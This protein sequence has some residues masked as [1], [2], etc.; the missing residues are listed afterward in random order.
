MGTAGAAHAAAAVCLAVWLVVVPS[1]GLP[2][3]AVG[4]AIFTLLAPLLVAVSPVLMR[5]RRFPRPRLYASDGAFALLCVASFSGALDI[6]GRAAIALVA[7]VSYVAISALRARGELGSLEGV[8]STA[9][10][11]SFPET[12][13]AGT[14]VPM[15]P[16]TEL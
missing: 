7:I 4:Y 9:A 3:V 12:S 6:S 10:P 5:G 11:A 14:G 8:W 16:P 15:L 2:G 1:A 13:S